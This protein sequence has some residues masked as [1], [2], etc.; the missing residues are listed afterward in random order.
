MVESKNKWRRKV[1]LNDRLSEL[2]E[3]NKDKI[4]ISISTEMIRRIGGAMIKNLWL[5]I[6]AFGKKELIKVIKSEKTKQEFIELYN[7]YANPE[8]L[9]DKVSDWLANKIN[10]I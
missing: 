1:K 7:K 3:R 2:W 6:W 4:F 10:K 8:I 5:W 9:F